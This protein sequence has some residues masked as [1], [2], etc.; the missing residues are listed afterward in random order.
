MG[1]DSQLRQF[2]AAQS[3]HSRGPNLLNN[4]DFAINMTGWTLGGNRD[5]PITQL[6]IGCHGV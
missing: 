1:V 3:S 2:D 4:G 6:V 5:N